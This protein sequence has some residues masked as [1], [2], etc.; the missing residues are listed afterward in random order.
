MAEAIVAKITAA[1]ERD[2]ARAGKPLSADELPLSYEDMTEAWLTSALCK[3]VTGAK[4]TG[5]ELGPVDTGSSNRRKIKVEYNTAGSDASL[6]TKLFCKASQDL[7]NRMVLGVSGGARCEVGF[8]RDIRDLLDIEAPRSY[9]AKLDEETFNS[10][11][12]LGDISDSVTEFCNDKTPMSRARAE[13]QMRL[14]AKTHGTI[15]GSAELQRRIKQF[16]TWP[17]FFEKTLSFGMKAASSKGFLDAESV[18]PLRLYNRFEEIWPLTMASIAKHENV[19]HTL[20]HGDVH[21][22]NWYVEGNGEMALS[23]WQCC[24]RGI[25]ARDV[26]YTVSSALKPEDRRAWEQDLLKL[27][28]EDMHAAGGPKVSF[29]EAWLA[30]R[31]QLI[32]ALTWWTVTLSPP[33]ALPDMQPRDTTLEFIRR[34]STAADDLDSL[35]AMIHG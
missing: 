3:K 13:S 29:N 16:S 26:A 12:I 11:I 22:K 31:Q 9:F 20:Q 35:D 15:Y 1:Y 30:Y 19:Q 18:I 33:D 5:F 8:Y 7:A 6:P 23:D 2:Q 27:Y 28:L 4:V 32:T 24:G 14:L 25:W 21:L 34:I 10:L 17:E